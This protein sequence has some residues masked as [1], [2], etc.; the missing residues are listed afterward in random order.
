MRSLRSFARSRFALALLLLASLAQQAGSVAHGV[1]L[2]RS[3]TPAG[4]AHEVCTSAGV[5]PVPAAPEPTELPASTG[6]ICD[7]CA[8]AN[9]PLL[10]LAPDDAPAVLPALR[11]E[12]AVTAGPTL[13]TLPQRAYRS[14]APPP[15]LPV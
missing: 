8:T 6:G 14:R 3:G 1:M 10:A 9:M 15:S 13:A 4:M 2:A 11:D 12:P 7:L 5:V